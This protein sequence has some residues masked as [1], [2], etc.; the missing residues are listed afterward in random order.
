MALGYHTEIFSESTSIK[1]KTNREVVRE[2]S[3]SKQV[4]IEEIETKEI[5]AKEA[6]IE[7]PADE[8]DDEIEWIELEETME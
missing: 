5:E 4:A 6:D 2:K 1:E 7:E 3:M 8:V